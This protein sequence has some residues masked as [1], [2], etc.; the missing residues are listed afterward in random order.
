MQFSIATMLTIC[1]LVTWQQIS[2]L[3]HKPLGYNKTEVISIPIGESINGEEAINLFK[4]KL[5]NDPVATA[6]SGGYNNLGRGNDGS[7][8]RAVLGFN[9]N[10]HEVRTNEGGVYYDYVKTLGLKLIAG[11]DFSKDFAADSNSIVINEKM[12]ALIGG[13]KNVV[14]TYLPLHDNSPKKQIIG[15][16]KDYNFRSLHEDIDPMTLEMT[17]QYA[18]GYVFVRVRS[19][20]LQRDFDHIKQMWHETFPNIEFSGSW[21]SENTEKQY[22]AEKRLSTIFISASIIAI[23]ISCIGLLAISIM[24]IVQRTKEIGIR[25]VLGA[26]VGGIV[27]LISREFV[28]LILLAAI[29]AMPI[30]WFTMHK[31]LE[32][33]AYRIT[34][35]WWI[36]GAATGIALVIALAT[37]SFQS[38]RA[39][40]ANPVKSLKSE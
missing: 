23:I 12:A 8:H 30:A 38:V 35:P 26:S 28:K 5:A 16:V 17:K 24:V 40:L 2:Y 21:L 32:S 29:I 3:Q 13:G 27:L 15:V 9:Y 1:T 36:F 4:N 7:M 34:I 19:N 31:W 6:V 10:G 39:A 37:I 14:G 20:N 11:R 33:F 25:K 22:N 18:M